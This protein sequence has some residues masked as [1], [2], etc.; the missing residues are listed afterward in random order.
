MNIV[1]TTAVE[2]L[3]IPAIAYKLKLKTGGAGVKIH[4]LDTSS[5]ATFTIDRRTGG[6]VAYGK[7]DEKLFPLAAQ[8]EALELTTGLPYSSR[9]KVVVSATQSAANDAQIAEADAIEE[10]V[11]DKKP[12]MV[13]SPEYLAITKHFSDINSQKFSF[14]RMNK[15]FIQFATKSKVVNKMIADKL[16]ADAIVEYVVK[17]RAEFLSKNKQGLTDAEVKALIEILDEICVRSAFKELNAH[18]KRML[19]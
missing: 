16:G 5:F 10:V 3:A 14:L 4:R 2:L 18:V 17:N 7:V 8:N 12:C 11:E 6:L 13:N 9:G 15:E 1:R 19:R